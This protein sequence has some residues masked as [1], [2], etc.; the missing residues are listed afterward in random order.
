[1]GENGNL[2]VPG[3]WQGA[4]P[5]NVKPS[6]LW[7]SSN[8]D[9]GLVIGSATG[10]RSETALYMAAPKGLP[11][12][13]DLSQKWMAP[14]EDQMSDWCTPTAI[15]AML[16]R[17]NCVDLD[18]QGKAAPP[19]HLLF[20]EQWL[21]DEARKIGSYAQPGVRIADCLELIRTL[22][23]LPDKEYDYLHNKPKPTGDELAKLLANYK[24]VSWARVT[25]QDTVAIRT[26]LAAGLP[27][28]L[29]LDIFADWQNCLG[30]LEMPGNQPVWGRH[31]VLI[32]GYDDKKKFYFIR[33]SWGANWAEG[34]YAWLP[35]EY[36]KK[37]AT[38]CCT[39]VDLP[40]KDL[41]PASDIEK[42]EAKYPQ[43]LKNLLGIDW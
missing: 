16:T 43:W 18:R 22:G 33:N 21:Y 14:I 3:K 1:M 8:P 15:V 36:A 11:D 9:G 2:I 35:Y 6:D 13:V 19:E 4:V 34:G 23:A 42:A 17:V 25:T 28:P 24:I 20:C 41:Y 10:K 27:V 39:V 38:E 32:V 29:A 5:P 7:L 31:S 40:S 37:Y 26:S 30:Y 12:K